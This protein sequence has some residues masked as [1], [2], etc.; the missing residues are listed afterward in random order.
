MSAEPD[1]HREHKRQHTPLATTVLGYWRAVMAKCTGLPVLTDKK[2]FGP[3]K[4]LF[5][6]VTFIMGFNGRRTDF[7]LSVTN[8]IRHDWERGV[9]SLDASPQISA[10]QEVT[11]EYMYM[12]MRNFMDD[13]FGLRSRSQCNLWLW[14]L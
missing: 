9:A 11:R 6:P 8:S 5:G 3:V 12:V 1:I 10:L 4:I 14:T 13:N 2:S 7:K